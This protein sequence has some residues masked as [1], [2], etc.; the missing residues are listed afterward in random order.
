VT[1]VG[2]FTNQNQAGVWSTAIGAGLNPATAAKSLGDFSIAIGGGNGIGGTGAVSGGFASIAIGTSAVTTQDQ[3][4]AIGA[5]A[6]ATGLSST[7]I[8]GDGVASRPVIAAGGF[9]TAIGTGSQTAAGATG[10]T[11]VGDNNTAK[12]L[13]QHCRR[14]V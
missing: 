3:S 2:T 6:Q 1:S 12:R 10:A 11:A 4:V 5:N 13:L 7:A 8:G 14:C 9:S